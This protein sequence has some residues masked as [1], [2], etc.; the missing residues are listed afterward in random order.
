VSIKSLVLIVASICSIFAVYYFQN[1]SSLEGRDFHLTLHFQNGLNRVVKDS[2]Y[3]IE[4]PY[5]F[6]A[7]PSASVSAQTMGLG[8]RRAQLVFGETPKY[9]GQ[10]VVINGVIAD[11]SLPDFPTSLSSCLHLL[12]DEHC[13]KLIG[14]DIDPEEVTLIVEQSFKENKQLLLAEGLDKAKWQNLIELFQLAHLEQTEGRQVR[15]VRGMSSASSTYKSGIWLEAKKQSGSLWLPVH[16]AFTNGAWL[17][18]HIYPEFGASIPDVNWIS[19]Y[20]LTLVNSELEIAPLP[21]A[22]K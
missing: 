14:K 22:N 20:G 17:A 16:S 19:G 6:L 5:G 18:T 13:S 3:A 4:L 10:T 1:T 11:V 12:T 8:E 2:E 7:Q 21:T 9:A 15:I